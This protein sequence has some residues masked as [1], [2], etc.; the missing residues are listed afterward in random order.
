MPV[1]SLEFAALEAKRYSKVPEIPRNLRVDHNSTVTHITERSDQEA[2][3]EFRFTASY[4]GVGVITIQ[5][6]L[7][8]RGDARGLARQWKAEGKMP[9]PVASE[10]HAAI[11]GSCIPEAVILARDVRLPPPIPMPTVNM[12]PEEAGQPR[13]GSSLEVA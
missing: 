6:N 1:T 13:K 2:N 11:L 9:N 7:L 3:V 10:I 5:G 12:P 8:F 4:M